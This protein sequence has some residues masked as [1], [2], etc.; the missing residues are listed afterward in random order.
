MARGWESKSVESQMDFAEE[1]RTR[2]SQPALTQAELLRQ[3]E[4]ES[5]ELSRGRIL[6]ELEAATHPVRKEQLRA[7]LAHLDG[8]LAKL[9]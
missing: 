2:G 8:L 6:R 7:A 4:R 3:R 1:A 5:I 9:V